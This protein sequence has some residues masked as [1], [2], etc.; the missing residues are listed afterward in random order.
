MGA[1]QSSS[2]AS[3]GDINAAS[4]SKTCYYELLG[5]GRDATGDEIKKAYRRKALELH[6]DRNLQDV[7]TATRRFAEIQSAHEILSDPQERA[8][9]DDHRDAILNGQDGAGDGTEPT[10]FRNIRL[11]TTEEIMSLMRKFNATVP[12][13]DEPTG[14]Y[15]IARETFEHLALEEEAA[16]DHAEV[17]SPDYPTFGSSDDDYETIVKP[18]YSGWSGFSTMKS[19]TWKDKYR[20]S[21]APD[22]RVRRLMEKENKKIREDAIREFNDAV[23]FLVTFVRKRDPRYIP[24]TQSDADRQKS[25]RDAAAKQAARSRAANNEKAGD[26]EDEEDVEVLECVV[27]DKTF[28]S[29]NQLEAHERSKKHQKAVHQ[30]RRHLRKEGKDLDLDP[31]STKEPE[32]VDSDTGAH[33]STKATTP[34]RDGDDQDGSQRRDTPTTTADSESADSP[35]VPIDDLSISDDKSIPA[36]TEIALDGQSVGD[37]HDTEDEG[38]EVK[39]VGKAKLKREKK[40]AAQRQKSSGEHRCAIC[41]ST[42]TSKTKLFNHIREEGHAAAVPTASNKGKKNR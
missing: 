38:R 37:Q 12:F 15:G 3:S 6:P 24:N 27:C 34:G 33:H 22:R 30:L 10:T 19:F 9:Y 39:K 41:A 5:V 1:Q 25:M 18:F 35:V 40:A 21:D 32:L 36:E 42:F 17:D 14:F 29:E 7:E 16:A 23:R 8:W 31:V 11:T 28:K 4:T 20:L 2:G 13:D 26:D